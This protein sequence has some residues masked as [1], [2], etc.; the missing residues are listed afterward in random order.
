MIG[1]LPLSARLD[2]LLIDKKSVS[3]ELGQQTPELLE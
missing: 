2:D 3:K 1:T